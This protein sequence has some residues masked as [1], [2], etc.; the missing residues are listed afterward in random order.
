M[1]SQKTT[2]V[3]LAALTPVLLVDVNLG[4]DQQLRIVIY[5]GN[6]PVKLA[7]SFFKQHNFDEELKEQLTTLI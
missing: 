7:Q 1:I 2:W 6:T 3:G 4:F 5:D